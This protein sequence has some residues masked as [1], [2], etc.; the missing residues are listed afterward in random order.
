[1][2]WE[3]FCAGLKL[4][5]KTYGW[6]NTVLDDFISCMQTGYN[7]SFGESQPMDLSQ[8]AK[9]WLRTKGVNKIQANVSA[10]NGKISKFTIE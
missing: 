2:G 4:Y 10:V 9:E 6:K 7:K 3:T 5:F 8:W 1:M